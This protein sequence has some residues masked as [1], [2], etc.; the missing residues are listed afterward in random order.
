MN[1][2]DIFLYLLST[3]CFYVAG[4]EYDYDN[5]YLFLRRPK[6][7]IDETGSE[8]YRIDDHSLPEISSNIGLKIP[9][10][11]AEIIGFPFFDGACSLIKINE[12]I[13]EY[14]GKKRIKFRINENLKLE[15][16]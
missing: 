2:K 1:N 11:V 14:L 13:N 6:Q 9:I 15:L 10:K 8:Y 4:Y 7:D 12:N 16:I 5:V 3:N